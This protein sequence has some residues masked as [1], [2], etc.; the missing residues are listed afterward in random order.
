MEFLKNHKKI[1]ESEVN[2]LKEFIIDNLK[3][4]FQKTGQIQIQIQM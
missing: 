2:I 4:S 1:T 3:T